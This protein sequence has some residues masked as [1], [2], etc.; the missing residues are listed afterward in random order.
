MLS[1]LAD[2][3]IANSREMGLKSARAAIGLNGREIEKGR[4]KGKE[5]EREWSPGKIVLFPLKLEER[6]T[7]H[8]G[9]SLAL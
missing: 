8:D 9:R 7:R 4:E 5:K 6:R 2:S 3:E 1:N